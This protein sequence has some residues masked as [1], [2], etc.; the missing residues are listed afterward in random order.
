MDLICRLPIKGEE[1]LF[2]A[3]LEQNGF[4]HRIVVDAYGCEVFFEPDEEQAYRAIIDPE[5]LTKLVTVELLKAITE[6][7]EEVVK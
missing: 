1:I 6:A 3:R 2:P 5:Q 4:T 7:I